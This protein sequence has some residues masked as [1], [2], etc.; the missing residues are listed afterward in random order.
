MDNDKKYFEENNNFFGNKIDSKFMKECESLS[1]NAGSASN[2]LTDQHKKFLATCKRELGDELPDSF[3]QWTD[4]EQFDHLISHIDKYFP[5]IPESLRFVLPATFENG[6]CG[7]PANQKPDWLDMDKFRRGQQFALRYYAVVSISN[8]MSLT[9]I[10]NFEDGLKP[11]ILSQNSDSPYRAFM[12]YLSTIKRFRNWYI[13]DPWREG[14]PAYRDIQTVRRLHG[15]MRRK[16]CNMDD[17]EIDRKCKLEYTHC[18]LLKAIAK[19]FEHSVCPMLKNQCPYT[20]TRMKGLNQGDMGGTQFACMSMIVLYPEK[21]GVYASDEELHDFC[22]LW[23]GLGY[24]LGIKDEYNFCRG[25]LQEIRERCKDMIEQ[26]IKPNYRN[27]TPEWEHMSTCLFEASNC[28]TGTANFK[29]YLYFLCDIFEL[30]MTR[31]YKSFSL[32]DKLMY[33]ALKLLFQHLTKFPYVHYV[34]NIMLCAKMEKV[35]KF[36]SKEHAN[37]INKY[38]KHFAY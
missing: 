23:R 10:F 15:A 13:S 33:A 19:D 30:N 2:D 1:R 17:E 3:D 20:M 14:T 6:D 32:L 36:G 21:F 35:S 4:K 11:L 37:I 16:L 26:W 24:L 18:P 7:R 31:L 8:L 38:S 12:R 22:Y 34:L 25:T 29:V 28:I 5:N 27:V 9:Q